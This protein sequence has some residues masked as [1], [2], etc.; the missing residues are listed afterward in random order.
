VTEKFSSVSIALLVVGLIVGAAGG[1]FYNSNSLMPMIEQ[2]EED[3]E[4]L[5]VELDAKDL[6]IASLED[7]HSE[8]MGTL[9]DLETEVSQIN[10]EESQT[11]YAIENLDHDIDNYNEKIAVLK[12][13]EKAAEGYEVFASY[14]LS[15]HYPIGMSFIFEEFMENPVSEDYC[16]VIGEINKPSKIED[17][18]YIWQAVDFTPDVEKDLENLVNNYVDSMSQYPQLTVTPGSKVTTN[19]LDHTVYYQ[20]ITIEENGDY[21]IVCYATWYCNLDGLAYRM[22]YTNY[23]STNLEGFEGYLVTTLCHR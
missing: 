2:L 15:F 16:K 23:K 12:I 17:V 1:Y 19:I 8:Q 13:Q 3:I 4:L 14:G 10:R 11:E 20:T 22:W 18:G 6:E 9:S 5:V 21:M 7:H